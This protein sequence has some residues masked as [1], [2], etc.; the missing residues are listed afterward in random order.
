MVGTLFQSFVLA[1]IL[2]LYFVILSIILFSRVDFFR[3][4]VRDMNPNSGTIVLAASIGLLMGLFLVD[5]H[6]IWEISARLRVTIICWLIL[7][8]SILW[9]SIPQRMLRVT[10][11]VF[12][13]AGYYW[14]SATLGISG[15]MLVGKGLYLYVRHNLGV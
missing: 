7:I 3:Q 15:L 11:A 14:L 1:H 8:L 2:G 12:S 9:L 4:L 10:Q 5:L 13:G 6:S